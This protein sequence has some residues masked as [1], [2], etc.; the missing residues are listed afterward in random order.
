MIVAADRWPVSR[1]KYVV[2]CNARVLPED[3]SEDY[4]FRYV[5][6]GS[7][8]QG[9]MNLSTPLI[10]FKDAPSRARRMA[11]A[12][13]TVI[14]TVRTYLRAV[15]TV[16]EVEEPLVF[17]TGFA[18]LHPHN[19]VHNRWLSYYLQSDTF[20]DRIV[21]HSQ[22][23]SYPAISA[24]K[25]ISLDLRLPPFKDQV[26][27]A[28]YLDRETAQIDAL[29]DKQHRL[30]D[31]L[32]ERRVALTL[33]MVTK[34]LTSG[35]SMKSSGLVWAGD[36]PDHWGVGNIRRFAVMKTGHTPSRSNPAYWVDCEIPWFTLADVWQIRDGKATYVSSETE[37][38]ISALDLANS[39]AELLPAGTV[40]LSRTASVGFAGIMPVPMATSQDYWNWVCGPELLPTYLLAIF[41]AMAPEFKRLTMGST[42]KTIYQPVAAAISVL[43]PPAKEQR[44]IVDYIDERTAKI[45]LLTAKAERFIE[46][47]KE[48]RTALIT[49]AVSGQIDV[50]E[51]VEA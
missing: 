23:V 40:M 24:A 47:T 49:A 25:M 1:L 46:L 33:Q 4:R 39:A 10:E 14:S 20:I 5:D 35:R 38:K 21:S 28:D 17:S 12:G 18:V 42:H 9:E 41:R 34:G 48:R 50:R 3:T 29:I 43:V 11:C 27:I 15:A 31:A 37:T 2:N 32:R 45:D 51:R 8:A 30:V 7:V 19:S 26:A 22:G 16:P 44:E 6:I 13:D 36:V